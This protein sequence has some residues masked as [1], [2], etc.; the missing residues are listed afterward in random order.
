MPEEVLKQI[1]NNLIAHIKSTKTYCRFGNK[2]EV[3]LMIF[4]PENL[5]FSFKTFACVDFRHDWRHT[6][7]SE[8]NKAVEW[9]PLYKNI[10]ENGL[11]YG[12]Q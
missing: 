5:Q 11:I 9:F 4:A 2:Q 6:A 10:F 3:L 12:W 8:Y 1:E 7:T